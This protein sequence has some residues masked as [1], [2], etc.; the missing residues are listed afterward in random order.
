MKAII[1]AGGRGERLR[2][3]TDN[4]P[5]PLVEVNGKPILLHTLELLKSHGITEFIIALC[6]LPERV[7]SYFGD[8]SKFGVHITYTYE[9]QLKPLG[10]AGAITLS[11][12]YIKE[13]FIVT[14]ADIVRK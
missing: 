6:Y 5:K 12:K 7:V 4:I 9:D 10:N 8:G 13:T 2:P 3:L 14:Y 11:Q 1:I